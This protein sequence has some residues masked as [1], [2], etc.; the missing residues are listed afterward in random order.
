MTVNYN[1]GKVESC[2]LVAEID[3]YNYYYNVAVSDIEK[4]IRTIEEAYDYYDKMCTRIYISGFTLV[5]KSDNLSQEEIIE[6]VARNARSF[7]KLDNSK[8]EVSYLR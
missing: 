3:G 8:E 5:G 7:R 1:N 6:R 4:S 2:V